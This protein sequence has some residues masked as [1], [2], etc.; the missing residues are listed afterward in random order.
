MEIHAS[1]DV[2]G[3]VRRRSRADG[4]FRCRA[5]QSG[6]AR[7]GVGVVSTRGCGRRDC[8]RSGRDP[9][10]FEVSFER[11]SICRFIALATGGAARANREAGVRGSWTVG[12]IQV[13]S[14]G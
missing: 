5:R 6:E 11:S 14:G 10:L 13:A 1:F 4:L 7:R 8:T 9:L 2:A 12:G 3:C